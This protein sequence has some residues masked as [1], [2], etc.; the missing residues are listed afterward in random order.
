[1]IALYAISQP[2]SAQ[3]VECRNMPSAKERIACNDK[4]TSASKAQEK[5]VGKQPEAKDAMTDPNKFL[6]EEDARMKKALKPICV[7]C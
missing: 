4:Q 3:T 6:D 2:A 7:H 1:V 5:K